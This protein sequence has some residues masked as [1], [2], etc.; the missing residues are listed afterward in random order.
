MQEPG[1]PLP[2]KA[3]P[4]QSPQKVKLMIIL[5]APNFSSISQL[6]LGKNAAGVPYKEEGDQTLRHDRFERDAYPVIGVDIV[7]AIPDFCGWRT[8]PRPKPDLDEG[9][10]PLQSE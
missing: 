8:I 1:H 9:L 5:L 6:V 4:A 10:R 3:P 7:V 2:V